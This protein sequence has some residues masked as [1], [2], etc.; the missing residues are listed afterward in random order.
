VNPQRELQK[1]L[2][3]HQVGD[4][5]NAEKGYRAVLRIIP[6]NFDATYL[7]GLCFLQSGEFESD[8]AYIVARPLDK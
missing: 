6:R 7:L 5:P 3:F 4:F 2:A 1:A 8:F